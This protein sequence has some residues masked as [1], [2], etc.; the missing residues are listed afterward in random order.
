M[1]STGTEAAAICAR[2]YRAPL[3]GA[4]AWLVG[5]GVIIALIGAHDFDQV[6]AALGL[7]DWSMIL[8][9]V[10]HMGVLLAD[11]LS[12]RA[13]LQHAERPLFAVMV[14]HR[15][16][17]S[18]VN[19]L[20]PT[21]QV[22]GEIV[23]AHLLSRAGVASPVAGA[24][25]VVDLTA[26]LA[27]QLAFVLVGIGLLLETGDRASRFAHLGAGLGILALLVLGFVLL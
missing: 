15:W 21:A 7:A 1:R 24:G 13:L 2:S 6:A 12:W 14:V 3:L 16:I 23:R 27:T 10:V 17:G 20:L 9:A 8:I 18:S 22:G 4:L 19:G 5:L 25:V 26:G 11:T